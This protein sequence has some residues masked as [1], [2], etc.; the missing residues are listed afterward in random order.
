MTTNWK[1]TYDYV[2]SGIVWVVRCDFNG[3]MRSGFA[4]TRDRARCKVGN[5]IK[6]LR[7]GVAKRA[8]TGCR[9]SKATGDEAAQHNKWVKKNPTEGG[10]RSEIARGATIATSERHADE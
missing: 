7:L 8:R 10:F 6:E 4:R 1:I 9:N 3:F 5:A 2:E